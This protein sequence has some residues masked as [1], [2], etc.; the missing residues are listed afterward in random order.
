MMDINLLPETYQS[1][2]EAK[3]LPALHLLV[4]LSVLAVIGIAETSRGFN[5]R[6]LASELDT[7]S[8]SFSQAQHEVQTLSE[9]NQKLRT[10]ES[11][12]AIGVSLLYPL[13]RSRI[14]TE[15]GQTC[16]STVRIE[17]L[18]LG[19]HL[20]VSSTPAAPSRRAPT[21]APRARSPEPSDAEIKANQQKALVAEAEQYVQAVIEGT[22]QQISDVHLYVQRL[23]GFAEVT[24]DTVSSQGEL[25]QFRIVAVVKSPAATSLLGAAK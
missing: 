17:R 8:V 2:Q 14:L 18:R 13:S 12:A 11:K 6:N 16:P 25:F 23:Q 10:L 21:P 22:A 5:T 1:S 7:V 3:R 15:L 24:L 4:V 20:A 19:P 9:L